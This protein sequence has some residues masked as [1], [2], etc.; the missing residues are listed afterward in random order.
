MLTLKRT[1]ILLLL[2]LTAC[3]GGTSNFPTIL[4]S[5]TPLPATSTPLPPTATP[6]PMAIMV[7][8]DGMTVDEFNAELARYKVAMTGLG[9][10]ISAE[11][12]LQTVRGDMINQLLLVQGASEAGFALDASALQQRLDTLISKIG[13][14]DKLAAWQQINNY[15]AASF[16]DALKRAAAGAWMRD[17]IMS[18]V[19]STTEQVHVRQILLYNEDVA[20]SYFEQLKTGADFDE[21]AAQVDPVTRGDIGWFPRGY[22]AEKAVEDAAFSLEVGTY[23]AIVQGE[24]GFHII[25]LLDRQADRGLSPDALSTLQSHAI[26]DWLSNRQQQ[27]KIVITP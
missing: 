11:Q 9:K 1:W 17:K 18:A 14:T 8:N 25:K 27:S 12:A 5:P 15:T 24:V 26:V 2:I 13:G 22:L 23:S 3:S 6:I 4:A 7:N 16:N 19:P 21:L 20:K 10:T